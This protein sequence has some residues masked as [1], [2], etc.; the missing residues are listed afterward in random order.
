MAFNI[1]SFVRTN[2]RFFIWTTFF[3]L[4]FLLRRMFGL[5]FLTYILCFI[6]NGV[7][8]KLSLRTKLPRRLWT[9]IIYLVFLAVIISL[10]AVT[11]PKMGAESTA[12]FK[13]LPK[14]IDQLH[15]Y[16]DK[17][18]QAQPNLALV[19]FRVKHFLSI[20]RLVGMDRQTVTAILLTSFNQLTHYFSFFLLGTLFSF[21][22]LFDF[23]NLRAR[24]RAL[25][26]TRLR[27]I[28]EETA[29]SV[30]QFAL[31]VGS[32]FQA[33]V[34]IACINTFLTAL[35]LYALGIEPVTL[36]SVI[37]FFCGLIP[38]LGVFISSAP[39]LLFA[40]NSGGIQ[41]FLFALIMILIVHTI[42]AYVLN[43]RIFS[44]V[45]K[46]NPVLTLIILYIGHKFLGLWGVV[47]GIPISVYIYRYAVLG[48][49]AGEAPLPH[50]PP[51][52]VEETGVVE[53]RRIK[54]D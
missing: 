37:V 2:K 9:V 48:K 7:I 29:D 23:P 45:F 36:L 12:F 32:A 1:A 15:D 46:I 43:P 17:Q 44:A 19:Y 42:E 39:I 51:K 53:V 27:E 11:A 5:I 3:L 40:F 34:M 31:V 35:G 30:A 24:T 47:L 16:L 10:G 38:V 20:E 26:N 41:L 22:I 13:Q 33:Q 50:E 18:A 54:E 52:S 8:E 6:F 21:F 25:K 4:L 49:D 14:T 28:Y